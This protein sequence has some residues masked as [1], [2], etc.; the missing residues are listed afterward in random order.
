MPSRRSDEYPWETQFADAIYQAEGRAGARVPYGLVGDFP[1]G[2]DEQTARFF[3]IDKIRRWQRQ[4]EEKTGKN[5]FGASGYTDAFLEWF[6]DR[7]AP[8]GAANDP[9]NLNQNWLGNVRAGLTSS[10]SGLSLSNINNRVGSILQLG[11]PLTGAKKPFVQKPVTNVD[12]PG[13]K[14]FLKIVILLIVAILLII[15]LKKPSK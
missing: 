9:N 5:S 1:R 7:Y 13:F 10:V 3:L 4:F 6:R 14:L 2:A 15:L 11:D 12:T 8:I